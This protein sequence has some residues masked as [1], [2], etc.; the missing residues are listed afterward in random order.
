MVDVMDMKCVTVN[1]KK[2]VW[3][4]FLIFVSLK[5]SFKAGLSFVR[6]SAW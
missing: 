2:E 6:L 5:R 3:V 1:S 4:I